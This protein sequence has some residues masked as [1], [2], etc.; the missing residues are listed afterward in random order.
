MRDRHWRVQRMVGNSHQRSV[1][2]NFPIPRFQFPNNSSECNSQFL[3]ITF[4]FR[5]K[6]QWRVSS[7]RIPLS[8]FRIPLFSF[9]MP[10]KVS[11]SQFPNT[12]SSFWMQLASFRIPPWPRFNC[13]V[14]RPLRISLLSACWQ[15]RLSYGLKLTWRRQFHEK[16]RLPDRTFYTLSRFRSC[17]NLLG[18]AWLRLMLSYASLTLWLAWKILGAPH[19][20]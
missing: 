9:R 17:G 6:T 14:C 1:G 19:L 4:W 5:N 7:F 11:E 20:K 12:T 3:N 18:L 10:L 8:S 2:E 16:L 15:L 13:W